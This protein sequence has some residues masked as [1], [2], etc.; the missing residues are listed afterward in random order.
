MRSMPKNRPAE[1]AFQSPK[2]QRQIA[3]EH[4]IDGGRLSFLFLR[5]WHVTVLPARE[6]RNATPKYPGSSR[7]ILITSL[8]EFKNGTRTNEEMNTIAFRL[9]AQQIEDLAIYMQGLE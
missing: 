1:P 8:M 3:V 6:F 7:D 4:S 9:S 2:W 5:A